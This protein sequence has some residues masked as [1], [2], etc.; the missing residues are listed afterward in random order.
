MNTKQTILTYIAVAAFALTSLFAAWDLTGSPNHTNVPRY[1]PIFAPP[2]LSWWA[3]RE[4]ASSVVWTWLVI[5]VVYSLTFV[6][7]REPRAQTR[8]QMDEQ[9]S[10]G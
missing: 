10:A 4:L 3:K 5:G 6:A 1:A 2:E 7:F 8:R 9:V